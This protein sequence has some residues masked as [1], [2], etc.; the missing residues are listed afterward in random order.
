MGILLTRLVAFYLR[1]TSLR[2][3]HYRLF[4][5]ALEHIRVLGRR[6]GIRTVTTRFGYRMRLDLRDWVDQFIYITGNYEEMTA[7]TIEASLSPGDTAVDIGANIGFFSLLMARCVGPTGAVWAFEPIPGTNQRLRQNVAMN[8]AT[9]I[10]VRN[11]AIAEDDTDRTIFGGTEDHSGIAGFRPVEGASQSHAVPVRRLTSCLPAGTR[12]RL[13]KIDVEGAE[14]LVLRGMHDLLVSHQPDLVLEMS[15]EYLPA[16]G[17][18]PTQICE[19]LAAFGYRMYWIDG[20]ALV[21]LPA[22][23]AGL[24]VQFNAF[25]TVRESLPVGLPV[26]Q[27]TA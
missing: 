1:R 19:Y 25:F 20:D 6:M 10:T 16:L 5:F 14:F 17:S 15:E 11:E 12:P 21:P 24:P 4:R 13:V 23:R 3:A 8:H 18:S 9:T 2:V 22:W 7:A 27:A 26:R